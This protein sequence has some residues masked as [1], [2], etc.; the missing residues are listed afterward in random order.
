MSQ[1]KL[2]VMTTQEIA[3]WFGLKPKSYLNH[4]AE[5]LNQLKEYAE[6]TTEKGK[7]NI[8]KII[9]PEY[10]KKSMNKNYTIVKDNFDNTWNPNGIDTS[11][12]VADEMYSKKEE[13]NLTLT[14]NSTYVYVN[15]AK[16]ELYGIPKKCCGSRG[17]CHYILAKKSTDNGYPVELTE[18]ENEIKNE[19]IKKYFFDGKENAII[20]I[21]SMIEKGEI[22]E[23]DAWNEFKNLT[24]PGFTYNTF[25][26]E[27]EQ[28]LNCKIIRATKIEK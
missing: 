22:E 15:E 23:R 12:R 18:E 16:R 11:K 10:V 3:E 20:I 9:H 13:L 25:I 8:T 28:K 21:Q 14:S 2:G 1:L 5:K 26:A 17:S 19:L 24:N 27:L 4:R 6:F 7:I